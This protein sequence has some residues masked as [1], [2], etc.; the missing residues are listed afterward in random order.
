MNLILLTQDDPFYLPEA[1]KDFV[2]KV[3][4]SKRHRII[5]AIITVPSPF[6]KG[7]FLAKN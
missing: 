3:S 6:G 7:K 4:N 5:N 2:D 1:I